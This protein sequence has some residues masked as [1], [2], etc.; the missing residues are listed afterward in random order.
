[1]NSRVPPTHG[2][3]GGETETPRRAQTRQTLLDAAATLFAERGYHGT[4]VPNIVRAAGVSQGTFYQ[5]FG[6]RR[7]V[8]VALTQVA[9]EPARRSHSPK[10]GNFA[11][12]MREEINWYLIESMRYTTLS[13]VWHDAA[14]HDP[15]IASMVR[16]AQTERAKQLAAL[17]G[18][19]ET[20]AGLIPEIAA[21]AIVAM[22]DEFT[23]RWLVDGE[24]PPRTTAE[25]LAASETLNLLISQALGLQTAGPG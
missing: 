10:P 24:G 6:N 11:D 4:T 25:V 20:T 2:L 13:K 16:Q 18:A 15:E 23:F 8:L 5:Y 22:I 3:E 19:I 7:D 9:R 12:L 14:A 1:M 21:I 17:I